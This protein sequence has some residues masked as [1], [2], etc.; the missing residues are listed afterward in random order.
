MR[1]GSGGLSGNVYL[2]TADVVRDVS[3]PGEASRGLA[4]TPVDD[5]T[6]PNVPEIKPIL[7]KVLTHACRRVVKAGFR[8]SIPREAQSGALGGEL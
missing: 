4:R 2:D 8:K 6:S 5:L 1:A 3:T 7:P